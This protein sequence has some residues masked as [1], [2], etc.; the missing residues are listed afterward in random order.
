MYYYILLTII[1]AQ[2]VAIISLFIAYARQV[3]LSKIT[4]LSMI[5]AYTEY[6]KEKEKTHNL[7]SCVSGLR[8]IVEGFLNREVA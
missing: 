7:K 3:R 1:L 8:A 6:A 4:K 2:L 5:Q